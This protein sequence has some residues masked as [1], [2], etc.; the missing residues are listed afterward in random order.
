MREKLSILPHIRHL[1]FWRLVAQSGW[2]VLCRGYE[3]DSVEFPVVGV[4]KTPLLADCPQ[5]AASCNQMPLVTS[6]FIFKA[7]MGSLP[8]IAF[9]LRLDFSIQEELVLVFDEIGCLVSE[10]IPGETLHEGH[11]WFQQK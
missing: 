9:P 4:M 8:G 2:L 1:C 11:K 6:A 7:Q 10:Q 3:G 5:E